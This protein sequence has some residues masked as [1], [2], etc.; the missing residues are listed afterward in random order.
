MDLNLLRS[1]VT[2]L[3]FLLFGLIAWR[4][5]RS[6]AQPGHADAAAL[7]FDDERPPVPSRDAGAPR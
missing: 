3:S 5:W 4:A 6:A 2:L 1:G 7:P